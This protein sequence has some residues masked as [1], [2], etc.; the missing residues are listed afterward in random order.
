M[1]IAQGLLIGT[2]AA[3]IGV[4]CLWQFGCED[5]PTEPR[6]PQQPKDYPVYFI[7]YLDATLFTYYP[8]SRRIDS[9]ALGLGPQRRVAVSADGQLLYVAGPSN[10]VVL[11]AKSLDF[12][13]E[14]P[15]TARWGVVA[16]PDNRLIAIMGDGL[17]ILRTGDFT[18]VF[19]DP[20]KV[21]DGVF[22]A[23]SRTFYAHGR[24]GVG[25]FTYLYW[26]TPLPSNP[27]LY[28][29]ELQSHVGY[30]SPLK[31]GHR[32]ALYLT[33]YFVMYDIV[34]DSNIFACPLWP[35]AG[36]L[37]VT[38]DE[39]YAFFS[40]P[41]TMFFEEGTTDLY[42]FDIEG[43]QICDTIVIDYFM[44]SIGAIAAYGVG[45]MVFT[46]DRRWMVAH[47]A[48]EPVQL[49]LFDLEKQSLVDFRLFGNNCWF[50]NISMQLI[51]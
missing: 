41:S 50:G 5:K 36:N 26:L 14:L 49:L 33:N 13:C 17:T 39:K 30:I 34:A 22:S 45:R 21:M 29:R 15:Y 24:D 6:P 1:R 16:S 28:Q 47:N 40:N 38:L 12:V 18:E 11:N 42:V 9:A 31:D 48:Q 32:L 44:D 23:D 7:N 51:R 3:A 43:N 35:G 19:V 25:H 4:V 20:V 27:V 8:L 37:G 46:P 10:V 2:V